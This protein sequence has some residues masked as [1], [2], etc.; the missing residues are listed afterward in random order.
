MNIVS[1]Q[2]KGSAIAITVIILP[3]LH[4]APVVEVAWAHHSLLYSNDVVWKPLDD[5]AY[6]DECYTAIQ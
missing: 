6:N 2:S 3:T 1:S 4:N 5:E